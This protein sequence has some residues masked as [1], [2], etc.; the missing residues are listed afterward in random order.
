MVRNACLDHVRTEQRHHKSH[1]DI[2]QQAEWQENADLALIRSEALQAIHDEIENLPAQ[3]RQIVKLI[4]IEG[5]SVK[6]AAQILDLAEQTVQNQKNRGVKMLK[7]AMVR[8]PLLSSG[9]VWLASLE[10]EKLLFSLVDVALF[11]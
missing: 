8:N 5:Y 1:E 7:K 10:L 9:V 3:C 4:Y 11:P 2:R 6:E